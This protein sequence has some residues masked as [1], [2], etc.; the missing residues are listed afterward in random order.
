MNKVQ[1][2]YDA[3]KSVKDS[4]LGGKIDDYISDLETW[5][6]SYTDSQQTIL[7]LQQDIDDLIKAG[8]IDLDKSTNVLEQIEEI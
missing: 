3:I 2:N 1:I 8:T 6:D 4:D 7:E 5:A